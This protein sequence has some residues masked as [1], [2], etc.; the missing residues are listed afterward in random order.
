M[1]ADKRSVAVGRHRRLAVASRN[2]RRT[3]AKAQ[4]RKGEMDKKTL[5]RVSASPAFSL[6][7]LRPSASICGSFFIRV[8]SVLNPWLSYIGTGENF[9]QRLRHFALLMLAASVAWLPF[10]LQGPPSVQGAE[11]PR[12]HWL[13]G[14]DLD[15]VLDN[16]RLTV[17]WSGQTLRRALDKLAT[18]TFRPKRMAIILDRRVDPGQRVALDVRDV[19]LRDVLDQL[20]KKHQLAVKELGAVIYLGPTDRVDRLSVVAADR[21]RDLQS[22]TKRK[23]RP[24]VRSQPLGW[25]DLAEPRD[26]VGQ[27]ALA[28]GL[29]V[30]NLQQV[31]H[32]LWPANRLPPL[33]LSNRL[34]LLLF[35]FDLTYRVTADGK[36][37]TVVPL[38]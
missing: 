6:F 38:D 16:S 1:N 21:R 29:K 12:I 35:G 34:T 11:P 32:D 30:A 36:T 3:H 17:Q 9:C 31:P 2:Q 19:S 23:Q 14:R 18:Q 27:L 22:L 20:A 8:Q 15:R 7:H 33:S 4:R 37:I 24:F 13:S 26:L 10:S 5:L 28:S 25:D